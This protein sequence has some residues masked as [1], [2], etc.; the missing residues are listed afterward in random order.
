MRNNKVSTKHHI[1]GDSIVWHVDPQRLG[2]DIKQKSIRGGL[3]EH[4]TT[5]LENATF[6]QVT[7]NLIIHFGTNNLSDRANNEDELID[8][9]MSKYEDMLKAAIV[10]TPSS[11]MI[12]LS[13]ILHCSQEYY[14]NGNNKKHP[15]RNNFMNRDRQTDC[16]IINHINASVERLVNKSGRV[17]CMTHIGIDKEEK[18]KCKRDGLHLSYRGVGMLC[19]D[20]KQVI[21]R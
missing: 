15:C 19:R 1:L 16:A 17:R 3:I 18:A 5:E 6:P 12:T 7:E 20:I 13:Q 2:P 10:N 9:I 4:A 21:Y 8:N 14:E 11:C